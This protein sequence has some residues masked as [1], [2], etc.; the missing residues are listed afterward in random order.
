MTRKSNTTSTNPKYWTI[1]PSRTNKMAYKVRSDAL[2]EEISEH[3]LIKIK[4]LKENLSNFPITDFPPMLETKKR[5]NEEIS[6]CKNIQADFSKYYKKALAGDLEASLMAWNSTPFGES[7]LFFTLHMW[8]QFNNGKISPSVWG[9]LLKESWEY[10]KDGCLILGAKIPSDLIIQ[11]FESAPKEI[12]M[13]GHDELNKFINTPETIEIW[14]GVSSESAFKHNGMSWTTNREQAMWFAYRNLNH[15]KTE[16][17][18]LLRA[19]I[20]KEK[21]LAR[22]NYEWEVVVSPTSSIMD[23]EE[24]VLPEDSADKIMRSLRDS[25]TTVIH[26]ELRIAA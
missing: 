6:A 23:V 14:R 13:N 9:T 3:F 20:A 21:I 25:L 1:K 17:P 24:T 12:L 10:G 18:T 11:M 16:Q 8:H 4:K 5:L 2:L 7:K 15:I 19:V 26:E 22:F